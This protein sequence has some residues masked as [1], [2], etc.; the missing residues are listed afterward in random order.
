M[1]NKC[2]IDLERLSE[3]K[4]PNLIQKGE[5]EIAF[6]EDLRT[7]RVNS[8]LN[9]HLGLIYENDKLTLYSVYNNPPKQPNCFI[10]ERFAEE[11]DRKAQISF[12]KN[13][14]R[15]DRLETL[16]WKK[17]FGSKVI[18]KNI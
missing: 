5:I 14:A 18:H 12:L 4:Q 11:T 10:S 7:D 13:Q 1:I 6:I 2:P 3:G 8:S 15:E 16:K 9:I 17:V